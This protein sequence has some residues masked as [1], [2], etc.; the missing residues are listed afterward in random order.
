[1]SYNFQ[2]VISLPAMS[3]ELRFCASRK[4]GTGGGG[5]VLG[6]GIMAASGLI[7]RKPLVGTGW[8]VGTGWSFKGS[9]GSHYQAVSC[10]VR[11]KSSCSLMLCVA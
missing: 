1:M 8:V 3:L 6:L 11:I 4:G 7:Y 2:L 10:S 9:P 5:R